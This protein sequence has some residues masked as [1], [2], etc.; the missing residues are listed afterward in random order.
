MGERVSPLVYCDFFVSTR[1][2]NG[3]F[4]QAGNTSPN[5]CS[6]SPKKLHE[7]AENVRR[8][9]EQ[10]HHNRSIEEKQ[11]SPR[12]NKPSAGGFTENTTFYMME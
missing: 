1:N 4:V 8:A 7:H 3:S 2:L 12:A 6:P 10:R 11:T 9:V 5:D